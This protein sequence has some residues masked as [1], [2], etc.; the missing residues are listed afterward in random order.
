VHGRKCFFIEPHCGDNFFGR[1]SFYGYKDDDVRFA[2]FSKAALE[3]IL[4]SGKRPDVIHCHDWQTGLVPVL[5]FEQY[6]QMGLANQRACYTIHNFRHQGWAGER[7]LWAT[8]LG[9]PERYFHDDRLGDPQPGALNVMKGGIVYANFV[10]SVSP[11]HAHEVRSTEQGFGLSDVLG[12]H[13]VKFGGVLNGVDYGQWNPEIDHHIP[14]PYGVD[15]IDRKYENKDALRDRFLLRKTYAPIVAFVGRLDEQKGMHLVHHALFYALSRG[16][17]FVLLGDAGHDR[18]IGS[19]F[20]HLKNYL[21]DHPDCHLEISYTDE[22]GHLVFAGSD[23]LVVPS[24]FEPCGLVPLIALRYGTV[25]VVR[26]VGGMVNTIR[27]RDHAWAPEW[28]RNGYVFYEA[29]N[30]GI[31]SALERALGLWYSHPDQFR[32]L[33]CNGMRCDYSWAGPGRDYLNIYDH[34]RHK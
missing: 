7:I 5:L 22:L 23:L 9:Q 20:W 18:R 29:D 19:H 11:H 3:F 13:Q 28:D 15:T 4:Q 6:Q 24:L 8:R 32:Y 2:F 16:A 10:T 34:I 26:G 17:Q 14:A 1:E 25:P 31:E 12:I 27:D 30:Q 33:Q 21:N